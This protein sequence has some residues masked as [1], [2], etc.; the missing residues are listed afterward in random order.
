MTLQKKKWDERRDDSRRY[1]MLADLLLASANSLR[2]AG[3]SLRRIVDDLEGAQRQRSEELILD[4]VP[5]MRVARTP[6]VRRVLN[7]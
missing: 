3:R 5:V 6:E 2:R 4:L 7:Q 1:G